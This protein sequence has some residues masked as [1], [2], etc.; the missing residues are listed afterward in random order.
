MKLE[1]WKKCI[2]DCTRILDYCESFEDGYDKSKTL[3]FKGFLR[4]SMAYNK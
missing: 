4:R 3:C 2:D 1:R